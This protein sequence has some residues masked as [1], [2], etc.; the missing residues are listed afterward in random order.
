MER[1]LMASLVKPMV[2]RYLDAEGRQ[3]PKGTSATTAGA[4]QCRAAPGNTA[5]TSTRTFG[6]S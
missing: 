4:L 2:A 5:A 6:R 1:V 3:M